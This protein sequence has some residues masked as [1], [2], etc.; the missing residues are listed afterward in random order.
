ASSWLTT[1]AMVAR[2]GVRC[3]LKETPTPHDGSP[4]RCDNHP[5]RTQKRRN[6]PYRI[7][8][9]TPIHHCPFR[10]WLRPPGKTRPPLHGMALRTL[11]GSIRREQLR[12]FAG[13]L[14]ISHQRFL[15]NRTQELSDV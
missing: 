10:H 3:N 8:G 7:P 9:E 4:L 6:I 13:G 11:R 5:D 14:R 1:P 15:G 2:Y 12:R